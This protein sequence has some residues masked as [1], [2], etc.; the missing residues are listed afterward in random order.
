MKKLILIESILI[1]LFLLIWSVGKAEKPL[2]L[3]CINDDWN[4]VLEIDIYLE[5]KY[6]YHPDFKGGEKL[7]ADISEF[8]I[9]F[10]SDVDFWEI[11]RRTGI[12]TRTYWNFLTDNSKVVQKADCDTKKPDIKTKF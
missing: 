2:K 9:K 4:S 1:L 11:D 10:S 5:N 7:S 6:I 3:Y 12:A 8:I